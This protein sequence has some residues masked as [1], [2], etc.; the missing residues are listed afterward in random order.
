MT[1]MS[2]L[3]L[4]LAT[5]FFAP[6]ASAAPTADEV[7]G[8][9]QA[10]YASTQKLKATFRQ[11]YTNT[12]FGKSSTSDGKVYIAKPGK[13]R[14][15]YEKPEKKYFISDGTTL[16]VYEEA[17]KQAFQL[18]LKDQI[19]PVAITFLYGTGNLAT[20]FTAALDPGKYGAKGDLVLKLT[21]KQPS[22]Q[23]KTLWLVV[24]PNDFHVKE[25]VILE[26]SDNLN[27]FTFTNIALNDAA[28][29]EDKHFKFV[30]PAGVKVIQ[31]QQGQQQ[32]Q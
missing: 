28:K 9:V 29:I 19:L 12:T 30:P 27:H 23:Y 11:E 18:S 7:V 24:D 2:F 4:F 13:M 17:N 6:A 32:P 25:S 3:P 14:W 8:K 22:A 21:P 26:A 16:W 1:A 5:L 20:E 31:P 10:Y 15:D